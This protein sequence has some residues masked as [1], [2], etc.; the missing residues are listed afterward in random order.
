MADAHSVDADVAVIPL[1]HG[2]VAD[3]RAR[4]LILLAAVVL[5]LLIGCANVAN[6]TLSRA[7]ARER[8]IGIRAALGAAPRRIARQVFTESLVLSTLGGIAGMLLATQA[9]GLL[10]I[11]LPADTP[12]LADVHMNWR[13]LAFTAVVSVASGCIF[14]LAPVLYARRAALVRLLESGGRAGASGVS[15][16]LRTVLTVAEVAVAVLLV[17]AAGLLVR[18]LWTLSHVDPGFRAAHVVTARITP[19]A[20]VCG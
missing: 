9:L 2:L 12:R 11:A 13:V 14:G 17:A 7:A 19:N 18:T 6:L 20:S 4:L 1:Q 10:K 8:E 15:E 16:R 5:V 3:V